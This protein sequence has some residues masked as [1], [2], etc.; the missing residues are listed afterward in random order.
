MLKE[1]SFLQEICTFWKHLTQVQRDLLLHSAVEV[2]YEA[3]KQLHHSGAAC[4]GVL[5]V[6]AGGIRVYILSKGGRDITLYRLQEHDV[7]VL[8]ASCVLDSI[9]FD[10]HIDTEQTTEGILIP[11]PVFKQLCD[12]NVYV[13]NFSYQAAIERFSDVM[14]T[15]EQ[16][17]FMS[18]DQRL[19][20]FLVEESERQSSQII[21]LSHEQIARY[22]SS[23]REVVSRM[24]KYFASEGWV[25]LSRGKVEILDKAQ[26]KARI[27]E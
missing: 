26:L 4:I 2:K 23:A 5:L 12:E 19:A 15:L 27:Q 24:L 17:L 8:A 16:I 7:C 11:A 6:K 14:W 20:L 13:Q 1:I 25:K 22:I 10:V 9:T 3:Q 21:E 18:F